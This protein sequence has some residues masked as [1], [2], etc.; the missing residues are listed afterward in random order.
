MCLRR[1]KRYEETKEAVYGDKIGDKTI[2]D[3]RW[4]EHVTSVGSELL[5]EGKEK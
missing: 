5:Y 2:R 3:V 4:S 1:I